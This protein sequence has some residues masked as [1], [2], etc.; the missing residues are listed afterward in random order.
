MKIKVWRDPYECGVNITKKREIDFPVGLTVLVGC[1]GAGK[2]TLIHNIKEQCNSD[3]I[4]CIHY[5]NLHDGGHHALSSMFYFGNYAEG[6]LL[7]SSSEGECVKLNVGRF[8]NDL[9]DFVK[10][11]FKENFGSGL[12]KLMFGRDGSEEL[13]K[14]IRVILL[15]ALDSGLSVDSLVELDEAL[16]A[17]NSDLL[18]TGL[19]YYLIVT[20]NEYELS[21]NHRCLDVESGEFRYFNNYNQYRNFIISSRKRKEERI[22]RMIRHIEKKKQSELKEYQKLAESVNRKKQRIISKYPEGTDP[23]NMDS[24]DRYELRDLGYKLT[25][26]ISYKAHYLTEKDV[27]NLI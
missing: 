5:D 21:V 12:A 17:F 4:P 19:E 23:E 10:D 20:A 14:G 25:D 26:F 9:G 24:R 16:T 11:G 22:D 7:M 2:S 18:K 8:L 3:H 6:A 13:D 1:N 27:E 15:D